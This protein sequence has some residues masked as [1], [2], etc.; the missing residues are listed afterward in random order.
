MS[1]LQK[2]RIWK[3]LCYHYLG[4]CS[5]F[6]YCK[7]VCIFIQLPFF[8]FMYPLQ[9][10]PLS[11]NQSHVVLCHTIVFLLTEFIFRLI[12]K[13]SKVI[14]SPSMSQDVHLL[15]AALWVILKSLCAFRGIRMN[16]PEW[17]Q[18]MLIPKRCSSWRSDFLHSKKFL[19][20]KL[21]PGDM[22]FTDKVLLWWQ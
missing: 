13:S 2:L 3:I 19:A 14:I 10:K 17:E 8:P 12:I 6:C 4:F 5:S 15:M 11:L 9:G 7:G 16:W 1:T 20:R 22:A 21:V 18:F